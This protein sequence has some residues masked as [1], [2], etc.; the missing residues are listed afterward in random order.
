MFG[1]DLQASYENVGR[2]LTAFTKAF[3][4]NNI[5]DKRSKANLDG[6][7]LLD[8]LRAFKVQGEVAVAA[9]EKQ[10]T[11]LRGTHA[12]LAKM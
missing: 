5:T 6:Q 11:F 1:C 10:I 7:G 9:C 12:P 2:S 3:V 4:T 8:A